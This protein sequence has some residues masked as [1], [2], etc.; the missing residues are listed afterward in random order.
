MK[1]PQEEEL[2]VKAIQIYST[3]SPNSLEY[4]HCLFQ[5][6]KLYQENGRRREALVVLE[7]AGELYEKVRP[8]LIE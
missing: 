1:K 7:E 3:Q 4:A 2:Y 8:C 6:G 5:L